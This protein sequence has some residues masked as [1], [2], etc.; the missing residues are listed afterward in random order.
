MSMYDDTVDVT[1][2]GVSEGAALSEMFGES[3]PVETERGIETI[4]EEIIFYKNVGGQAVIEIGRRLTEAK[5]Q[6]KHG[7]WLPWLREKVEFSETSAQNFMRI[8]R[9]YGNTHLVGDLG[10]SKA[11]VLLALPASERENFA[12]EKHLVNGEEKSVSEMSK[13]ELEE[14]IRQRKLAELERDKMQRELDEQ[15]KANEEAAAEMQKAQEAA[16]AARAAV[17]DA[18]SI[19]LAA[20]ERTAELEREL[21]ALREKPVDVAVQTVDASAEQIAAAVKEAEKAAKTKRDAAVAKKAEELKAAEAQR[22]EAVDFIMTF[23]E[24]ASVLAGLD[25]QMEQAKPY[26]MSFTSVREAHGFAQAGGVMGAVKAY[27]KEEADKIN[28]V[29]VANLDKKAIGA[30]RAYAKSGKAPGQFIE[31]MACEGG[32]IT[33]PCSHNE[34]TA[35]KRQLTQE[36]AK[37]KETY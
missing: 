7:E 29:Q 3:A 35:G 25:I 9:E 32:C 8:A 17:E 24:V 23:E 34:I 33:G 14:A 11:L 21:K 27:L 31:V 36:L 12:S 16:E 15:R 2:E 5:A 6:L 19:S 10:A 1:P 30:L 4:T 26:S 20:Q 37:R 18:K 22:D 28:A 13:R